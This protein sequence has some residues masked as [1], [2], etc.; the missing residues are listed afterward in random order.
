MLDAGVEMEPDLRQVLTTMSGQAPSEWTAAAL[1]RIK[2]PTEASD[3]A[4]PLKA[5]YGSLFPYRHAAKR[6]SFEGHGVDALPSYAAGGFSNVWG[7]TVLP[8]HPRDIV[9]WPIRVEDLAPHYAAVTRLMQVAERSD[10][11]AADFPLYTD[12]SRALTPSRQAEALMRDLESSAGELEKDGWR[13]GYSRLAVASQGAESRGCV[14]CGLCLYGCPYG[15]IYNAGATLD[16]LR[17]SAAFT[18]RPDVIVTR[19]SE[20]ASGVR[21]HGESRST[22]E[23]LSF[24]GDRVCL[25]AGVFNTTAILLASLEAYDTPVTVLDSQLFL[26]PTLRYRGVPAVSEETPVHAV[27][28]LRRAGGPG[29]FV[30]DDSSADL[31]LQRLVRRGHEAPAWARCTR[32]P[33][34]GCRCCSR[35]SW[36]CRAICRQTCRHTSPRRSAAKAIGRRCGSMRRKT[37]PRSRPSAG[38]S[39]RCAGTAATCARSF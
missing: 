31:Q 37:P 9:D 16:Q 25:A 14:Y 34:P 4:I 32:S 23:P 27:T 17:R 6:L 20:S 26:V 33:G 30:R 22:G 21:I 29:D 7:A 3:R 36:R 39:T 38:Y 11:L 13:F 8:Y 18:Y 24:D 19:V 5:A 28:G 35:G 15:L 2:R 1:E 12:G 10:R